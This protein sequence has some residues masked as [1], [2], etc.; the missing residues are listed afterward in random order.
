MKT[1]KNKMMKINGYTVLFV[2]SPT[3]TVHIEV[4]VK[5]GF[6][7]ET[8]QTSGMNHLMEHA[9]VSSWK[10]CRGSCNTYWDKKGATLNAST[11]DTL[12]KY[13]IEG[14]S[15]EVDEMVEYISAIVTRPLLNETTVENEKK[16]VIDELVSLST[17]SKISMYDAFYKAFYE[18]GLKNVEDTTLQLKNLKKLT[19]DDIR[20]AYSR[21]FN[22]KT[23]FFVIYGQYDRKHIINLFSKYL[24][25]VHGPDFKPINCFTNKHAIIY[26]PVKTEGS[27]VIIGFPSTLTTEYTT[28]F[29]VL[30]HQLLF[31]ELRTDRKLLYD[32]LIDISTTE[33][34]TV[35]TI[36]LSNQNYN[37]KETLTVLFHLLKEYCHTKVDHELIQACIKT[38]KYNYYMTASPVNSYIKSMLQ[39]TPILTKSK[40]LSKVDSFSSEKFKSLCNHLFVFDNALCV[41]QSN[42][43]AHISWKMF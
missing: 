30:L 33:C 7:H 12:M 42:H 41:Y 28:C 3:H 38:V 31:K 11:D 4:V 18:G 10:K 39:R 19:I 14:L 29:K 21:T 25:P 24:N 40:F 16:A 35:V 8:K 34:G 27:N 26:V 32:I 6:I 15:T 23:L 1:R 36:E 5:S 37:I 20:R 17:N 43:N 22:D 9:I 13:Y 2:N